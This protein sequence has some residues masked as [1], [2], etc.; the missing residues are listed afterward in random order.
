[1]LSVFHDDGELIFNYLTVPTFFDSLTGSSKSIV[2]I[3]KRCES[4][5]I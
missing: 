5:S 1:M 2:S 3:G 4:S